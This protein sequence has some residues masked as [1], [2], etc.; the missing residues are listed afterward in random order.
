[1]NYVLGTPL[2]GPRAAVLSALQDV[3]DDYELL[4]GIPRA[5]SFPDDASFAFSDDYPRNLLLEDFLMNENKLLVASQRAREVIEGAGAKNNEIL[6][7]AIVDHK[8]R[9]VPDPYFIVHQI[10]LQPCIDEAASDYIENEIDRERIYY[11][12]RLVL[13]ESRIDSDLALFRIARFG[14]V[15]VFRRDLADR[16]TELGLTGLQFEEVEGWEGS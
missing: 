3:E 11:M 8:G 4:K 6:S 2:P 16:I 14:K 9:T 1:V 10:H 5:E 7:V 12:N 13:D 15:P